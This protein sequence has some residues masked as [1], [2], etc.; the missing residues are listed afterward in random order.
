MTDHSNSSNDGA[1]VQSSYSSKQENCLKSIQ[2][3]EVE[4]EKISASLELVNTKLEMQNS[5]LEQYNENK[6]LFDENTKLS[7]NLDI[8]N[9]DLI[10][11]KKKMN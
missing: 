2:T 7:T 1:F 3:L 5:L 4:K 10:K 6:K 9:S 8:L 11:Y